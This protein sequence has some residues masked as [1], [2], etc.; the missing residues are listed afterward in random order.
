MKKVLFSIILISG[1]LATTSN[2]NAQ[3]QAPSARIGV[4]DIEMMVRAMPGYGKV[5]TAVAIY[6]RDSLGAEYEFY[7]NEFQRLD[8]TFKADSAKG[9]AKSVLDALVQQRQQVGLNLVYWQQISQNKSE[10]KRAQLSQPLFQVVAAA[11][12][13]VLQQRK[14]LLVLKPNTYE[15]GTPIENVFQYVAR[16]LKIKLP[17]E[18]GGDLKDDIDTKPATAPKSPTGAKPK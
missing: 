14:Y 7:Q 15:L 16:E 5:D 13:K 9:R 3:S 17:D 11:Y 10:A 18:L 4:F 8:S 2:V 12:N 1:I 6:N